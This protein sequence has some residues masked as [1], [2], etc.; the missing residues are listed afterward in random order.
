[1]S[2]RFSTSSAQFD[3]LHGLFDSK[4]MDRVIYQAVTRTVARGRQIAAKAVLARLTIKRKYI[5]DPK[6]RH[7]A[8]K[9][10]VRK[11]QAS[12]SI[13]V[14]NR[15]LPLSAFKFR[16][17][18]RGVK[19]TMDK[20]RGQQTFAHAFK[21][22]VKTAGVDDVHDGHVGIF[23]RSDTN[24]KPLFPKPGRELYKRAQPTPG[25][26]SSTG[27]QYGETPEGF[28]WRLGIEELFGPSVLSFISRGEILD[29]V[30]K[31]IDAEF[32]KQL[33]SAV[34]RFTEG[35]VTSLGLDDTNLDAQN[36]FA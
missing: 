17:T 13:Y 29:P 14:N 20:N 3:A 11:G 16:Q 8:I 23:E 19:V 36:L 1:M 24:I 25:K 6:N 18:K 32:D 31:Q 30:L 12:G 5:D 22:K 4:K 28:A 2:A 9:T 15:P 7:A 33:D 34:S 10:F 26:F 21:A 27:K 35:K